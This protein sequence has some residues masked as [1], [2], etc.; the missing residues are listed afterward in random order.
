MQQK[1][2][3]KEKNDDSIQSAQCIIAERI[4]KHTKN[5]NRP[6]TSIPKLLLYSFESPTEPTSYLLESSICL[7]VQGSKRVLLG[8][9]VYVYDENNYLITSVGLPVVAQIIEAS[10]GKPYLGLTLELDQREIAQLMVDN[11]LPSP[12]TKQADRG[13]AVSRLTLPL[14][15]AFRRLIDLLDQPEDIPILAPMIHRE[16]LYRL[17]VGEQG[18]RLRQIG[19][20]GSQSQQI[21]KAVNWLKNNY[22]QRLHVDELA[23]DVGMSTS[24]FHHH[25]RAL[26]A[27]SPLQFQKR[28][29]LSEART[30][31]LAEHLDAANAA[32]RV[33]YESPSQF[34]RE[35]SRMFGAPPSRDIK[36][37]GQISGNVRI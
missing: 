5:N 12:R 35:Y 33:G 31:M 10:K 26:T 16:I 14:L 4:E 2:T 37:L 1:E 23:A 29:R 22:T 34:S 11:D 27:L 32:F 6:E 7:I 8:E 30:L 17:L 9:E 13:M 28:L 36:D 3:I 19:A 20:M 25:F 21:A 18:H 24:T 15:D